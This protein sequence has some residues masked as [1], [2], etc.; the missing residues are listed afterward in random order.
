[1][2]SCRSFSSLQNGPLGLHGF[3]SF[4]LLLLNL[5]NAENAF[6]KIEHPF[7]I[8]LLS[9]LEIEQRLHLTKDVSE[10]VQLT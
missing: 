7:V 9:E 2:T 4:L 1:M 6:D 3:S 8:K 10:N 5:S